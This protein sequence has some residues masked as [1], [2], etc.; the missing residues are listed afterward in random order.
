MKVIVPL[1]RCRITCAKEEGECLHS[2]RD[3]Q[4]I[5]WNRVEYRKWDNPM[6]NREN[7]LRKRV[8]GE[9]ESITL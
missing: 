4:G 2:Y 1:I 7:L 9:E 3:E 8:M 5:P 6:K